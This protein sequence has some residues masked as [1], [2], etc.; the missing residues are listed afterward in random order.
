[1][2]I[3]YTINDFLDI[4]ERSG[5]TQYIDFLKFDEVPK[6]LMK[7][8]DVFRRHFITLKVGVINKNGVLIKTG[9]VFFQRYTDGELWMGALFEGEFIETCG[10]V[11]RHQFQLIKDLCM[12]KKVVLEYKH[13]PHEIFEGCVIALM[14]VW[15]ETFAK[16]IQRNFVKARYDPEY[17]LCKNILNKQYEEYQTQ[18]I[19]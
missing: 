1:M 3:Y 6:N 11:S 19:N 7:G 14:D 13:R 9:Q 15:E 18:L 12:K 2:E 4:G 5:F 17:Q 8:I 16:V 10:G